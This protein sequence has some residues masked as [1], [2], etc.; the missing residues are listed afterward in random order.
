M[1]QILPTTLRFDL[2][3][4]AQAISLCQ[5]TDALQFKLAQ[6][7]LDALAGYLRPEE[8]RASQVLMAQGTTDRTVY[9]IETGTLSVHYEDEK[10]RIRM[11]MVGPGTVVGEGAF[12]AHQPRSAT[13]QAAGAC[14]VWSL[15]AQRF[16]ELAHRHPAIALELVL[17][18]GGVMAKRLY[19]RPSRVAVT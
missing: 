4:L 6:P 7:Q 2:N 18:M 13:V 1:T 12:F 10:S 5:A 9:F 16:S 11:A 17:A 19:N 3:G 14:K 8:I 15:S